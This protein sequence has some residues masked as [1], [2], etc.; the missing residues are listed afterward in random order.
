MEETLKTLLNVVDLHKLNK[1]GLCN[2]IAYCI[3]KSDFQNI[4]N[5]I[6]NGPTK[7]DI[8]SIDKEILLD[9]TKIYSYVINPE[10]LSITGV[11]QITQEIN[12]I[13]SYDSIRYAKVEGDTKD[14]TYSKGGDYKYPVTIRVS[15]SFCMS[16]HNYETYLHNKLN[17]TI[18]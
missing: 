14:T 4:M 10:I 8:E 17:S 13:A 9:F 2:V 11:N 18:M 6:L 12:Y 5:L 15:D 1:E 3:E 16:L 7:I